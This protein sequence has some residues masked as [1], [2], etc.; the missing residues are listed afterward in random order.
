[1]LTM[2]FWIGMILGGLLGAAF[3]VML[4]RL[5]RR[6]EQTLRVRGQVSYFTNDKDEVGLEIVLTNDGEHPV[7]PHRLCLFLPPF[8][9]YFMFAHST[10]EAKPLGPHQTEK[11]SFPVTRKGVIAKEVTMW[12]NNDD[13]KPWYECD[14]P[15]ASFRLVLD[16]GEKVLCDHKRFGQAF[17]RVIS[18]AVRTGE[19]NPTGVEMRELRI[20]PPPFRD[21]VKA[22]FARRA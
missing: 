1:M 2:Q 16:K 5:W 19:L 20:E 4:D 21:R 15:D 7:P 9:S 13:G 11:F 17:C 3:S 18:N 22:A 6:I 8:G 14:S 12:G 10:T